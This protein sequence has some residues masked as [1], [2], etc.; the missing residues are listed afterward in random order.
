MGA[1]VPT[2]IW[3]QVWDQPYVILLSL[4]FFFCFTFIS[5]GPL[6][7]SPANSDY[8]SIILL[9][10]NKHFT[11]NHLNWPGCW[12]ATRHCCL[13]F[14]FFLK[15]EVCVWCMHKTGIRSDLNTHFLEKMDY[16]FACQL[17]FRSS[18]QRG[19][20]GFR[21]GSVWLLAFEGFISRLNQVCLSTRPQCR[22]QEGVV[23]KK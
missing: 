10:N 2:L 15:Y 7:V 17:F 6:K 16:S 14:C 19:K 3:W 13:G 11:W 18:K 20:R 9:A 4:C 12:S 23:V 21:T 8:I 1:K 22:Q 5:T